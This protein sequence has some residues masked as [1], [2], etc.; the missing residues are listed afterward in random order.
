MALRFFIGMSFIILKETGWISLKMK[1]PGTGDSSDIRKGSQADRLNRSFIWRVYYALVLAAVTIPS[2]HYIRSVFHFLNWIVYFIDFIRIFQRG[3]ELQLLKFSRVV[4][5]DKKGTPLC[6]FGQNIPKCKLII[7]P[8][9]CILNQNLILMLPVLPLVVS[10]TTPASPL[11]AN[12]TNSVSCTSYGSS[13]PAVISWWLDGTRLSQQDS[14]VSQVFLPQDF[15]LML[16]Y[17][18]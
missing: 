17:K 7:S 16:S 9:V 8:P 6:L 12:T 15:V 18:K 5:S 3:E 10:I 11:T 13:P 14:Q 4:G 2:V 1:L